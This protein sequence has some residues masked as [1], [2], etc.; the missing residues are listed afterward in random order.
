MPRTTCSSCR[1]AV[2]SS[3][4]ARR[5][6]PTSRSASAS[7]GRSRTPACATSC[8]RGGR[9]RGDV[10]ISSQTIAMMGD[11]DEQI[12]AARMKAKGQIAFYGSTPA[13]RVMLDHHG[14]GHLQPEL[15]AMSKQGRWMDMVGLVTDDMLD[16]VGVSGRPADVGR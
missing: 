11:T 12:A 6:V 8:A 1:A 10:E 16:T 3:G 9:T 5:S 13:Y 14:W 15:N 4:S 2:S 7:P